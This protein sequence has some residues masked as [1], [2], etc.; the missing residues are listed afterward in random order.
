V[1]TAGMR[2]EDMTPED[3]VAEAKTFVGLCDYPAAQTHAL[4]AAAQYL[5]QLVRPE[6]AV[7]HNVHG[8]NL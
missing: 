4:I 8:G 1:T 6:L 7:V 2:S 5:G 3:H